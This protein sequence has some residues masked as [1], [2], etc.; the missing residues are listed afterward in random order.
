MSLG[1]GTTLGHYDVTSL[2][3]E[4]GMVIAALL[5][6][7]SGAFAQTIS[8][9]KWEIELHGG[10]ILGWQSSPIFQD[11][12]KS[13]CTRSQTWKP[14]GGRSPRRGAGGRFGLPCGTSCTTRSLPVG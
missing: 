11:G 14:A 1:P 5:L 6:L 10:G 4:G 7:S 13:G 9:R 8:D 3:G 2:L 12:L